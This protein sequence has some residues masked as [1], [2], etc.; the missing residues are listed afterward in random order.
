M[1]KSKKQG[2]ETERERLFVVVYCMVTIDVLMIFGF[3]SDL[4]PVLTV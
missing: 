2:L 1:Q 3:S 4:D